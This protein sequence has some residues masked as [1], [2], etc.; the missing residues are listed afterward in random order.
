MKDFEIS[1]DGSKFDVLKL[2]ELTPDWIG[3]VDDVR[4]YFS[5]AE[6]K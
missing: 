6:D 4:E 1:V 2:I 3:T 5:E